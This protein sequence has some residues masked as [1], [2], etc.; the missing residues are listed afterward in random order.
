[1]ILPNCA[2]VLVARGSNNYNKCRKHTKHEALRFDVSPNAFGY[3]LLVLS[4]SYGLPS[5]DLLEP[6]VGVLVGY[7]PM[8]QLINRLCHQ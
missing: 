8:M 3:W 2:W 6:I 1:M 5:N 7:W 4:V